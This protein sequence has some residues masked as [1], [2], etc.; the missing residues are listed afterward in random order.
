MAIAIIEARVVR[1]VWLDSR[2]EEV[3]MRATKLR[4]IRARM[5]ANTKRESYR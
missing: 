5:I 1:K 4:N 2:S 3:K